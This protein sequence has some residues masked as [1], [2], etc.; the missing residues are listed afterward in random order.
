MP[1]I[2]EDETTLHPAH[3]PVT[4]SVVRAPRAPLRVPQ[5]MSQ[6]TPP[7][8]V[9]VTHISPPR[10]SRSNSNSN[11]INKT[12]SQSDDDEGRSWPP[13]SSESIDGRGS[14]ETRLEK[15]PQERHS[16]REFVP[17]GG[18]R[19]KRWVDRQWFGSRR[20]RWAV[21]AGLALVLVSVVVGLAL[22]LTLGLRDGDANDES[23]GQDGG[24]DSQPADPVFPAGSY[25]FTTALQRTATDCTSNPSTWRC[26][27]YESGSNATFFWIITGGIDSEPDSY[28][29]S[30]TENPFAPSFT[31]LTAK[32]SGRGTRN[33]RLEFSFDMDK[34]VVP[35]DALTS[36]NRAAECTFRGTKFETTLWTRRGDGR[37]V[38]TKTD[39][40]DDDGGGSSRRSSFS[41]WPADVEIIQTMA[42]EEGEP[43]CED[44][45]GTRITDVQAGDGE[46]VCG[47]AS[48]DWD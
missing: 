3:I 25:S 2:A 33:E 14:S 34:T 44:R 18:G 39:D 29:V 19:L 10:Y 9:P 32:L 42:A 46:C 22:G 26:F 6:P 1:P 36:D 17:S 5:K 27:P 13:S 48:F 7:P 11:S 30:S 23:G 45:D 40:D 12:S 35:S 43:R 8:Y 4:P 41:P 47:Y 15:H 24:D 21:F 37:A 31:N 20:K 28:T 38:D 16:H